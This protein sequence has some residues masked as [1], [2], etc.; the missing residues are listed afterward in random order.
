MKDIFVMSSQLEDNLIHQFHVNSFHTQNMS[1]MKDEH[2]NDISNMS[3][4]ILDKKLVMMNCLDFESVRSE[5][6][7]SKG[8]IDLFEIFYNLDIVE[9]I[10]ML[11]SLLIV[12]P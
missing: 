7:D 2:S 5:E 12:P 3:S 4:D 8:K 10:G 1:W 6:F 11:R 9:T